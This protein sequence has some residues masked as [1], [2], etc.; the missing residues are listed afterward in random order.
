MH[1]TRCETLLVSAVCHA[2]AYS[3]H[4]SETMDTHVIWTVGLNKPLD[5]DD[6]DDLELSED[7]IAARTHALKAMTTTDAAITLKFPLVDAASLEA[8]V[9]PLIFE[10]HPVRHRSVHAIAALRLTCM[11]PAQGV[12][13]EQPKL[14]AM[15]MSHATL[16][17]GKSAIDSQQPYGGG[18]G[19]LVRYQRC[20]MPSAR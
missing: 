10:V 12:S 11:P 5:E 18:G 14:A 8:C 7:A 20:A 13:A 6:D 3:L 9:V 1:Q 2:C 19:S 15:K 16:V 4:R 17:Q